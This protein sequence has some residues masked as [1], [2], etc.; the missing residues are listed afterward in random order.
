MPDLAPKMLE[1]GPHLLDSGHMGSGLEVLSGLRGKMMGLS[2][3]VIDMLRA[4]GGFKRVQ[5]E[6]YWGLFRR[7]AVLV[8]GHTV[9]LGKEIERVQREGGVS[10]R[11]VTGSR[12]SGKS[13]YLLQAMAMAWLR[14]WVVINIPEGI[15]ALSP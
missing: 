4:V 13:V 1:S 10:R 7:P 3:E 5:G 12:G 9:R 11:V 6:G 14:G 8:T 2:N 15:H